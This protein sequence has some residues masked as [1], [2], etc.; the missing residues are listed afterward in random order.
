MDGS[1][2]HLQGEHLLCCS[3]ALRFASLRSA[4]LR[5]AVNPFKV[6]FVGFWL[7]SGH[8]LSLGFFA[9]RRIVSAKR[10][11]DRQSSLAPAFGLELQSKPFC[12]L[13]PELPFLSAA[14]VDS[15][16]RLLWAR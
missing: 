12:D 13:Y 8:F 10:K 7:D 11:K 9:L 2:S 1:L 6:S 15:I 3:L 4:A 16:D 14:D 5:C